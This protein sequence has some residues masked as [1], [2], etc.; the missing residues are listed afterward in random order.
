MVGAGTT[1]NTV[2]KPQRVGRR[3]TAPFGQREVDEVQ[4]G[5]VQAG[6]VQAEKP[7]LTKFRL[8]SSG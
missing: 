1:T 4:A 2:M 6:E 3:P 5:E 7:G 8:R